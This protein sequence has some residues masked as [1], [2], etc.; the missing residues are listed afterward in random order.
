[1]NVAIHLQVGRLFWLQV[2]Q[3]WASESRI[4]EIQYVWERK[5][6]ALEESFETQKSDLNLPLLPSHSFL[7]L[8]KQLVW[9]GSVNSVKLETIFSSIYAISLMTFSCLKTL[10]A[11]EHLLQTQILRGRRFLS[12]FQRTLLPFCRGLFCLRIILCFFTPRI[13]SARDTPIHFISNR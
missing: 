5:K 2:W 9:S 8:E 6:A 7:G 3:C 4:A 1:M 11:D 13:S 10:I 12:V